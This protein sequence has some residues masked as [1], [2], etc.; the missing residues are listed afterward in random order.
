M[1]YN[2]EI[3]GV[4]VRVEVRYGPTRNIRL[5]YRN[6]TARLTVPKGLREKDLIRA[7]GKLH[8]WLI[9]LATAKPHLFVSDE[10]RAL[11]KEKIILLGQCYHLK[12][13]ATQSNRITI[14]RKEDTL[15]MEGT[16]EFF[17]DPE[18]MSDF[19]PRLFN[20]VFARDIEQRVRAIND[21]TLRANIGRISLKSVVSRWGSCS[22]DNNIMISNRLLLA[23]TEILDHVIIHEL[24]HTV[25]RDHSRQFW[26]VVAQYDPA[27]K[28]K[29]DWLKQNGHTLKY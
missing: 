7:K 24:A 6:N 14:H 23:P 10:Y 25:H 26:R 22:P 4:R 20:K 5:F 11:T 19:I 15:A 18:Q 16:D 12:F 27:M 17:R 2:I 28:E 8:E 9:N 29:N 1:N 13:K 21:Q 3:S